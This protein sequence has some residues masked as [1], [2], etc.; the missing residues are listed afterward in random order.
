MQ[1]TLA[2][3][4]PILGS[5]QDEEKIS[6][7]IKSSVVLIVAIASLFGFEFENSDVTLAIVNITAIVSVIGVAKGLF[8]KYS[9]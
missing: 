2:Q 5:S 1:K 3:K 4:Y 6:L 9:N 8:R 7:T